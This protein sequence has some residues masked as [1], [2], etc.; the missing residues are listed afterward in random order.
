MTGPA[1]R[2]LLH[3]ASVAVVL[4]V[5]LGSGATLQYVLAALAVVAVSFDTARIGAPAFKERLEK[6]LPV[7][8]SAEATRL[9]GATWLCVGYAVA[10]LFPLPASVAGIAAG[11]VS[12][13]AASWVGS[14]GAAVGRKTWWGSAAAWLAAAAL[15]APFGLGFPGVLG[16]ATVAAI[17]ER[18]PGPCDDNLLVAPGVA[19]TVWLMA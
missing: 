8:R 6:L 17:L 19:L 4:A 2:R 18:W 11:A 5:P 1:L 10:A 3:V 15:L 13:P 9:S 14:L 12:D 7:F 16:G